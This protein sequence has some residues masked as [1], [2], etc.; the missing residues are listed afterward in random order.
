M[1]DAALD[2]AAR[3]FAVFPQ[4]RVTDDGG[5]TCRAGATCPSPGKHPLASGW[6]ESATTDP[7]AIR[8]AW[9]EHPQANIG[10]LTG[11]SSGLVVV[12][13]DGSAAEDWYGH[14]LAKHGALCDGPLPDGATVRTGRGWHLYLALPPGLT[15]PTLPPGRLGPGVEVRGEGGAVTA[16]PSR[17]AVGR[18]YVWRDPLPDGPL[19]QPRRWFVDLIEQ[20]SGRPRRSAAS[21]PA[22][23]LAPGAGGT[24]YG[25]AAL[26]GEL[27]ELAQAEKGARNIALNTAA[28]RVGSLAAAGH[29][30]LE[31]AVPRLT[32]VALGLGLTEREVRSTLASGLKAGLASPR[33]ER[34]AA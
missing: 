30:D 1:L 28:F 14:M 18:R 20:A 11:S 2:L 26:D 3:G 12:D 10:I 6:R 33:L 15:I 21:A 9:A 13:L 7:Q 25:L 29:L 32:E 22:P 23:R 34:G 5:C 4:H 8:S 31:H 17:H 27:A 19:P 16:P 24:P